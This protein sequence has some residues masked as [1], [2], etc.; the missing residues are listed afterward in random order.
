MNKIDCKRKER[1]NIN[2]NIKIGKSLSTWLHT[3]KLSPTVILVK[4]C[5]EMGWK[6]EDVRKQK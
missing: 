3:E 2:I 6:N 1:K 5:Q 4:A